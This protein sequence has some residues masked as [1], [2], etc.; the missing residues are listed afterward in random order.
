MT[1]AA[2]DTRGERKPR[3][4]R[5]SRAH[6]DAAPRERRKSRHGRDLGAAAQPRGVFRWAVVT[7]DNVWDPQEREWALLLGLLLHDDDYYYP[8]YYDY[9]D[10]YDDYDYD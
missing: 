5:K 9:D 3:E 7:D 4:R 1:E 6:N 8:Y 2:T 10:Y